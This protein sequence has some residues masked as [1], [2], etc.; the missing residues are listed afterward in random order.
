MGPHHPTNPPDPPEM[1]PPEPTNLMVDSGSPRI[2]PE[3]FGLVGGFPP[4]KPEPPNPTIKSKHPATFKS[5]PTKNDKYRRIFCF[6]DEVLL[7]I[8]QIQQYFIEI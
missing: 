8:H 2:E 3:P 5:I 1:P 6:S 7:E 4:Q